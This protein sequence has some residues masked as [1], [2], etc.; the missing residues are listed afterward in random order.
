[1][2]AAEYEQ[3]AAADRATTK[4]HQNLAVTY[5]NADTKGNPAAMSGHCNSL[6]KLYQQA[7]DENQELARLHHEAAVD[8][9]VRGSRR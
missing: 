6:A 1:M 2:I 9:S 7:A 3:Q 8:L 5:R 4:L